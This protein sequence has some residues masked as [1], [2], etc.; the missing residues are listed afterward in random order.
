MPCGSSSSACCSGRVLSYGIGLSFFT[1]QIF[2]Y[3]L[4][5]IF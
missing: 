4:V 5:Y 3:G 2:G 1:I